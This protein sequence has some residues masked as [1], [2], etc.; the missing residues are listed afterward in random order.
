MFERGKYT[1]VRDRTAVVLSWSRRFGQRRRG[2]EFE[3][4]FHLSEYCLEARASSLEAMR[5]L[6]AEADEGGM[7]RPLRLLS[8]K[9]GELIPECYQELGSDFGSPAASD[10]AKRENAQMPALQQRE[11]QI[12]RLV[13]Q[14]YGNRDVGRLLYIGEETVKWYLKLLYRK[15]GVTNRMGAVDA[16][17]RMGIL[18]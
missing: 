10:H 13:S 16:A 8:P 9:V 7:V 2:L 11:I 4:L 6:L 15:L 14:G 12:I 5:S 18:L 3:M 17:R 1:D